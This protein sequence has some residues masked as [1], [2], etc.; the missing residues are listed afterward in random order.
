MKRQLLLYGFIYLTAVVVSA[1]NVQNYVITAGTNESLSTGGTWTQLIGSNQTEI[2][3]AITPIG[4]EVWFMGERF[5]DFS[6]NP[7]GIIRFGTNLIPNGANTVA[8][9][10]NARIVAFCSTALNG[11]QWRTENN[12]SVR[13]RVEGTAPNRRLVLDWNNIRMNE[14]AGNNTGI[15]NFQIHVYE[16]AP[17]NTNG[18]VGRIIYGRMLVNSA[19][20][21]TR[22]GI[23]YQI[24]PLAVNTRYVTLNSTN[25]PSVTAANRNYGAATAYSYTTGNVTPLNS[26]NNTSRRFYN[27]DSPA[28]NGNVANLSL[29]CVS[30]NALQLTWTEAASNEVG[31]VM[32]RSTD[33][34]N[35]TFQRQLPANTTS[36]L[37]VGLT[38][39]TTY[40]YRVFTVTEGRLSPLT[41]TN[42]ASATT[43]AALVVQSIIS[44]NW[45]NI[46]TWTS[47][48]IPLV[49]QDV[50][51]GCIAPHTVAVNAN[52]VCNNLTVEAGSVL[53]FNPGQTLTVSGTVFNN[54][55]INLNGGT[56][57]VNGNLSNN[58]IL[59]NGTGT[60]RLRGNFLNQGFY[61]AQTG[62]FHFDGNG[63]QLINH[64]GTGSAQT[65]STTTTTA[66]DNNAA[67]ALAIPDN[68]AVNHFINVPTT[69]TIQKITLELD[70]EH[71]YIADLQVN[72]RNP[73]ATNNQRV[74]SRL[75]NNTSS[76]NVSSRMT[77]I[78][79]S[80]AATSIQPQ[81][82]ATINGTYR[83]DQTFTA[84]NGQNPQGNWRIRLIDGVAQDVG[85]LRSAVLRITTASPSVALP[86]SPNLYF[87]NLFFENTGAGGVRS[88]NTDVYIAG[89]TTWTN[90]I[91]Y[92]DNNHRMRFINGATSGPPNNDSYASVWVNKVGNQSFDFPVG[93]NNYAA[94]I[95]ITAPN[96]ATDEFEALYKRISPDPYYSRALKEASINHV[97]NCEFWYLNR[98]VG[99]AAVSVRLSYDN[100]RSCGIGDPA[101]LKVCRWDGSKW[102]DHFNGGNFGTPYVGLVSAAAINNFSPFTLGSQVSE[103]INPLPVTWLSFTA[104]PAHNT[105]ALLEW[106]TA[107]EDN[108]SHFVLERSADGKTFTYLA[109]VPAYN[110]P[111]GGRYTYL[112]ENAVHA[113]EQGVLYYRLQ[114]IDLDGAYSYAP[115]RQVYFETTT[116]DILSLMPNPFHDQVRIKYQIPQTGLVQIQITD[117]LG[118]ILAKEEVFQTPGIQTL[119]LD[120]ISWSSGTYLV[121]MSYQGQS[122]SRKLV[123]LR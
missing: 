123:K 40:Y 3:S 63:L 106:A 89:N 24:T 9:E 52:G 17:G 122:L 100:V 117:V 61:N 49:T 7:N 64:T 114:Q 22:V 110:L 23:G 26:T 74:F 41:A 80:D 107:Q 75:A 32:Y 116:F 25:H 59:N 71:E 67:L 120:G 98:L 35:Y 93:A 121:Q 65:K 44:S 85:I 15:S 112:D 76:C 118:R 62:N 103:L 31:I 66:Y 82:A 69:E 6:V 46:L 102:I 21:E 101:A 36:Y 28:P 72:L 33:G 79:D 108:N 91:F 109:S 8:I 51:I 42:Q 12:G 37:D 68:D 95:G 58:G 104:E 45:S 60:L 13:Y 34:V 83:P 30:S 2:A 43:P 11:N 70:L 113:A 77:V 115:V 86:A 1:Q 10:N 99:N 48:A 81:C 105:D 19:T 4:F 50:I 57:I 97:S 90:G 54:G 88:Q 47:A 53:N 55:T 20:V 56:L 29:S 18:G 78:F 73:G 111:T 119:T 27:F 39:G 92:A 94:A 38:P 16:T 87:Y 84:F 96:N 5:T 14:S